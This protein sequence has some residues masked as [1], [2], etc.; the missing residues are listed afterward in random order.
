[1]E[2]YPNESDGTFLVPREFSMNGV[3]EFL[4]QPQALWVQDFGLLFARVTLAMPFFYS[5][6]T[7]LLNPA[8]AKEELQ[9]LGVPLV[10]LSWL[11]TVTVQI[12]GA[13]TLI[14]GPWLW[15]GAI[16]L[17]GF[18]IV[19]TL[20]GH[21]FWRHQGARF[22]RELTTTFEHLGIVGALILLALLGSGQYAL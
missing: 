11:A 10:E 12:V 1:M 19:A 8:A 14:A 6:I 13:I 17:A 5:G 3:L 18:T 9:S 2:R 22:Q 15:L 21:Q 7:K 16:L 4:N 20:L